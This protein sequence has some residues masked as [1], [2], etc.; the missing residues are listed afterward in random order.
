M[1]L[2]EWD[3]ISVTNNECCDIYIYIYIYILCLDGRWSPFSSK[4]IS[5]TILPINRTVS[6]C[7]R[8][9]DVF[10]AGIIGTWVLILVNLESG[11]TNI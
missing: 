9:M 6:H 3:S 4:Q 10:K 11:Y 5:A 8:Y 1:I 7:S 2:I